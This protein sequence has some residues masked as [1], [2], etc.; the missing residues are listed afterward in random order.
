MHEKLDDLD[1]SLRELFTYA[2]FV[3]ET[4]NVGETDF[5]AAQHVFILWSIRADDD[6]RFAHL[7]LAKVHQHPTHRPTSHEA[8]FIFDYGTAQFYRVMSHQ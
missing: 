3:L 2:N 5:L 7:G 6:R 8:C 4:C 1:Y